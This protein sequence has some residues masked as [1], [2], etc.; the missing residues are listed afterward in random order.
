[1]MKPAIMGMG[2]SLLAGILLSYGWGWMN[3][4]EDLSGT[5]VLNAGKEGPLPAIRE[6]PASSVARLLTL[7]ETFSIESVG[8]AFDHYDRLI[9][10]DL[11]AETRLRCLMFAVPREHLEDVLQLLLEMKNPGKFQE[12]ACALFSRWAEL[13]PLVALNTAERAGVFSSQARRGV[14]TTW[15]N[16][17]PDAALERILSQASPGDLPTIKEF[18]GYKGV[19]KPED[20]AR[21]LDKI[22]ERWPEAD[23]RLLAS[24]ANQWAKTEPERAAKWAASYD[25]MSVTQ[26]LLKQMAVEVSRLVGRPALE[27]SNMITD[28]KLRQEARNEVMGNWGR[29]Y[30]GFSLNPE[31]GPGRNIS[32]GFPADW[33]NEDI[34]TFSRSF[35]D[36]F[37][38]R[39]PDL[40]RIAEDDAQRI[41]ICESAVNGVQNIDPGK[42]RL[43]VESLS[44]S[45]ADG[46]EGRKSLEGFIKRWNDFDADAANAWLEAQPAGSK[47]DAMASKL[48]AE[49]AKP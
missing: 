22:F 4:P 7:S 14:V 45:Y 1:M 48:A 11:L 37:A 23:S 6:L 27:V 9:E 20:A 13:D 12:V 17:D 29:N 33:T 28:P 36:N 19:M 34:R 25:D 26:P 3:R 42:V 5:P 47:K 46:P 40:L 15:L 16:T 43:A 35:V 32:D 8:K 10:Q 44:D 39:L 18:L 31:A 24:V 30:G 49:G 41:L 2:A 21:L 38:D